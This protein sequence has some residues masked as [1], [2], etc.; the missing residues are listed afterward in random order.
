MT[1]CMKSA[2]G[3]LIDS[4]TSMKDRT[5]LAAVLSGLVEPWTLQQG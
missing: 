5:A 4:T 1:A 3:R 2:T